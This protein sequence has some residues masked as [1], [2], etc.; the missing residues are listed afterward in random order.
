MPT[1]T[2]PEG[3][4]EVD[5]KLWTPRRNATTSAAKVIAARNVVREISQDSRWNRGSA[6]TGPTS[7]SRRAWRWI[8]NDVLNPVTGC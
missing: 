5:G 3:V 7:T 2:T 6:R 4:I 8:N 1:A